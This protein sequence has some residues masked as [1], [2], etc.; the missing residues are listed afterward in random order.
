M[1]VRDLA[2][3]LAEGVKTKGVS[4]EYPMRE[5][6]DDHYMM[7]VGEVTTTLTRS[8]SHERYDI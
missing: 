8:M 2:E 1:N 5:Y 7:K 3:R 4:T 6:I